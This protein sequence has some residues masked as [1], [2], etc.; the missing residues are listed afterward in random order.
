MTE[1][2][3]A[4]LIAQEPERDDP[5]PPGVE[6]KRPGKI[7]CLD[8]LR[9]V[10]ALV[11]VF[12][13]FR[14]LVLPGP[15]FAQHVPF[16]FVVERSPL[17]LFT[18]ASLAVR[19]FFVHSGFVLSWKYLNEPDQRILLSMALRR[20]FRLG[21]PIAVAIL[22]AF[23]LMQLDLMRSFEMG[24]ITFKDA[25]L[26]K[27]Y[28]FVPSLRSA[29]L[30][31]LGGWFFAGLGTRTPGS[32]RYDGALWTM[33]IEL[34][35]SYAVFLILP[36]IVRLR[37]RECALVLLA[38]S[39]GLLGYYPW[40]VYFFIGILLVRLHQ[41]RLFE[42]GGAL[43]KIFRRRW[44]VLLAFGTATVL[45]VWPH[46]TVR[47]LRLPAAINP[48]ELVPLVSAS[49]FLILLFALPRF[50]QILELPAIQVLGRLSF[51]V[52]LVHIP[53][54]CSLSSGLFLVLHRAG[55]PYGVNS[56]VTLIVTL[57]A[58]YGLSYVIW[59]WVDR[60]SINFGKATL[61]RYLYRPGSAFEPRHRD[62]R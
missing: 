61:H 27:Q 34:L 40:L 3:T 38:A 55:W 44:V 33:P 31:S 37:T 30:D 35:C 5:R 19:I 24:G 22:F 42:P 10:A 56:L 16:G 60:F 58:A 39:V 48:L 46:E 29:L 43:H 47:R 12:A 51:A 28:E 25:P 1:I 9:G 49:L 50:R 32:I 21:I 45:G 13:H 59:R 62:P 14:E 23:T 4:S 17:M 7:A 2:P 20:T 18:A 6:P 11:V 57:I 54:L 26:V 53:I 52:Y 15:L 41:A 36:L 8:G